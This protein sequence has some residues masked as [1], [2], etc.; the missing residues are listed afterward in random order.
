MPP[1][2]PDARQSAR[3]EID[4]LR[5]D[6]AAI[7]RRLQRVLGDC[8]DLEPEILLAG[9]ERFHRERMQR[10][11]SPAKY[12]EAGPWVEYV[13]EVDRLVQEGA[14]LSDREMAIMRSLSPYLAFRGLATVEPPAP[15]RCRVAWIPDT[16]HGRLHIKNVDDP[17]PPDWPPPRPA[18]RAMPA[19][20]PLVWDGVGA[21]LHID[22]EPEEIFP[23]PVRAMCLAQCTSVP[24]AVE[25]L[26][27]Y[28]PFW[29]RQNVVLH[30]QQDN[31]IAI[32]KS[33]FNHFETFAPN[34]HGRVWVSGMTA[35]DP[36]SPQG[37]HVR[38]MRQKYLDRF[39]LGTDGPDSAFWAGAEKLE[40]MLSTFLD[41]PG[42]LAIDDVFALFLTTFPEGLNKDGTKP[43]PDQP[44]EQYTLVTHGTLLDERVTYRYERDADTRQMPDAP[45]VFHWN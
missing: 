21:G 17:I 28:T 1:T 23:L 9:L 43:H 14:G 38:R 7:D 39:G 27:R 33:S 5:A 8:A 12:P 15:E 18:Y 25:F 16:D 34:A 13:R 4:A 29:A 20:E 24:Q 3:S 6:P 42:P 37:Q 44:V 41:Q 11:P 2:P 35:R 45:E 30:D 26:E 40:H 36:H 31:A 10:T 19:S 32:E 22:D